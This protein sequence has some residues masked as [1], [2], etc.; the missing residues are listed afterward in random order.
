VVKRVIRKKPTTPTADSATQHP[1]E[2]DGV[3]VQSC[4]LRGGARTESA[5]SA[6]VLRW[7]PVEPLTH[8]GLSHNGQGLSGDA[9]AA[10]DRSPTLLDSATFLDSAAGAPGGVDG[11]LA[12][13]A[14]PVL[15]GA[16][17]QVV[18]AGVGPASG[19]EGGREGV[20]RVDDGASAKG[21]D[22]AAA[23]AACAASHAAARGHGTGATEA[24]A[25]DG[26]RA[27]GDGSV[28]AC[29]A[30]GL[31][32]VVSVSSLVGATV[33]VSDLS[34]PEQRKAT[35]GD[36][37]AHTGVVG[38]GEDGER[39]REVGESG[40]GYRDDVDGA[41]RSL[42]A[43]GGC[44]S[45]SAGEG[46]QLDGV[47]SSGYRGNEGSAPGPAGPSVDDGDGRRGSDELGVSTPLE[48]AELAAGPGLGAAKAGAPERCAA[49]S[50]G[51]SGAEVGAGD[52]ACCP[53]EGATD[54]CAESVEGVST[55]S[56]AAAGGT[57]AAGTAGGSTAERGTGE[58]GCAGAEAGPSSEE[59]VAAE[60]V[61][62]AASGNGSATAQHWQCSYQLPGR[63]AAAQE[64]CG[65]DTIRGGE[66]RKHVGA[67]AGAQPDDTTVD[68]PT[69]E[70]A[71]V[72]VTAAT[73]LDERSPGEG[74]S[75]AAGGGLLQ[76]GGASRE[77]QDVPALVLASDAMWLPGSA[78]ATPTLALATAAPQPAPLHS[79]AADKHAGSDGGGGGA[80]AGGTE[81]EPA[82][83]HT[84]GLLCALH[85]P[86]HAATPVLTTALCSNRA[87]ASPGRQEPR[88]QDAV[89]AEAV[90]GHSAGAGSA[91]AVLRPA[92]S[93]LDTTAAA[94]CANVP[95][96]TPGV[97]P[98]AGAPCEEEV[99]TGD[100]SESRM[101]E[102][103]VA[104]EA[105]LATQAK[106]LANLEVSLSALQVRNARFCQF[107]SWV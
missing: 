61:V 92:A 95:V 12:L 98:S 9:E 23:T 54:G 49:A 15:G 70:E 89:A 56:T 21:R 19:L 59:G 71:R 105:Q 69:H 2:F 8:Q 79:L 24:S 25:E 5:K 42:D 52:G 65:V 4:E 78:G 6:E 82:Q 46:A 39:S 103:L 77:A 106:Q 17:F 91:V 50:G 43:S 58:R 88:K 93:P 86:A 16:G 30:S 53:G 35:A 20:S 66:Q 28:A 37:D 97:Q 64:A 60:A 40:S 107:F 76:T 26:T 7:N 11:M 13:A 29:T 3:G 63:K 38:G 73:P 62:R 102:H 72:T 55:S 1:S 67:L 94:D 80:G 10:E 31:V 41:A 45:D 87:P 22:A 96:D 48:N 51:R 104:R 101:R 68:T 27:G 14:S 44:A 47:A 90:R 100:W 99:A 34:A 36:A 32:K 81:G 83:H 57:A 75:M 33:T 85:A 84:N 18:P 74:S